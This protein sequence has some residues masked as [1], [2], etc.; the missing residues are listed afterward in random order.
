MVAL[1]YCVGCVLMILTVSRAWRSTRLHW[2]WRSNVGFS[3]KYCQDSWFIRVEFY[4][5]LS[6]RLQVCQCWSG[7]DHDESVISWRRGEYLESLLTTLFGEWGLYDLP[8]SYFCTKH[9][10]DHMLST[11][12]WRFIR[13]SKI[14]NAAWRVRRFFQRIFQEC[15]M[16]IFIKSCRDLIDG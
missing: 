9:C 4:E 6:R 7:Y 10:A 1:I 15:S 14:W 13:C 11:A 8:R 5:F 12:S 16:S 2:P 3:F